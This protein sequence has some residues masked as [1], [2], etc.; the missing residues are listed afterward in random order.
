MFRSN[1]IARALA[2]L[3]IALSAGGF[4][5]TAEAAPYKTT[6]AGSICFHK[7][8][9]GYKNDKTYFYLTFSGTSV[10]HYNVR[11]QEEG[12]RI[13]QGEVRTYQGSNKS[14][15]VGVYGTPGKKQTIGIQ[16]CYRVK[17]NVGPFSVGT[18]SQCTGW[19]NITYKAV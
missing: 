13:K 19:S 7:D 1:L 2:P 5:A 18:K 10:T 11:Y 14:Q 16:A 8:T 12:G 17:V 3:A 15:E 9:Q 4:A 6:C